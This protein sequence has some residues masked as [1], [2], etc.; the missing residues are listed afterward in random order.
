VTENV[1]YYAIIR[2]GHPKND[3]SG[4]ARRT[5]TKDGRLDEALRRNLAWERD[6]VIY[7]WERGEELSGE[8]VEISA[9]EAAELI[10]R[11][12]AEWGKPG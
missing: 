2:D 9:A 1:A 8:L 3:P 10:E 5:F 12:R 4:L 7:E 11:F 6:S